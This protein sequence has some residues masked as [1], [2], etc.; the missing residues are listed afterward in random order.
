MLSIVMLIKPA[1][2]LVT[3]SLLKFKRFT[4]Y[5]VSLS[6]GQVSEFSLIILAVASAKGEFGPEVSSSMALASTMSLLLSGVLINEGKTI[7]RLVSPLLRFIR[8]LEE[9][10]TSEGEMR[11]HVV[12]I[13]CDRSGARILQYLKQSHI[14]TSVIDFN[15]EIYEKLKLEKIK[16]VFGDA[17]NQEVADEAGMDCARMVISTCRDLN[18]NLA[19]LSYL[20]RKRSHQTKVILTAN[21]QAEGDYLTKKGAFKVIVPASLEGEYIVTLLKQGLGKKD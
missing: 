11:D 12:L 16:A 10:T 13:G 1:V 21:N 4:S 9:T 2:F 7:Y 20:K 3:L 14:K 15:P 17:T 5:W 18:D 8:G 19:I 6:L